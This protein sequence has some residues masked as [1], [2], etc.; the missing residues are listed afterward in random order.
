MNSL[1]IILIPLVSIAVLLGVFAFWYKN[2]N[3]LT[4]KLLLTFPMVVG[5]LMVTEGVFWDMVTGHSLFNIPASTG[6]ML[7][8]IS[9]FAIPFA[10]LRGLK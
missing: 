4:N 9:C 5:S 1:G 3:D 7:M 10:I 6:L 8:V 2:P